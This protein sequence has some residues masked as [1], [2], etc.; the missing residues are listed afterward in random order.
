TLGGRLWLKHG[1]DPRRAALLLGAVLVCVPMLRKR[2]W[3]ARGVE[4]S[5]RELERNR[6]LRWALLG[7]GMAW[8]CAL[9][10]LQAL[11]LRYPLWDVGIFHQILWNLSH[12]NG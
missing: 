2:S 8:A 3:V 12:G 9:G 4:W 7:F 6:P 11:A 1:A 5:A 10:A